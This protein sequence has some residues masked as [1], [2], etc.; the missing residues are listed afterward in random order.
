MGRKRK[1][2]LHLKISKSIRLSQNHWNQ[3]QNEHKRLGNKYFIHTIEHVIT[4]Y[5]IK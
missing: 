5:F 1:D 2:K 3:L 4:K